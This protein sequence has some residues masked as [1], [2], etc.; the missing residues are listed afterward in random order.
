MRCAE[1]FKNFKVRENV[2]QKTTTDQHF[3]CRAL[4]VV[5]SCVVVPLTVLRMKSICMLYLQYSTEHLHRPVL[6]HLAESPICCIYFV[7]QYVLQG[8]NYRGCGRCGCTWA[9]ESWGP[10]A[11]GFSCPRKISAEG[12]GVWRWRLVTYPDNFS[13]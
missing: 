2:H 4:L 12:E 1:F 5:L 6:R 8:R 9:R 11:G 3:G 13:V 7:L 10:V